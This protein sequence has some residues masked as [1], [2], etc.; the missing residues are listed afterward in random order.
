[1]RDFAAASRLSLTK[2]EAGGERFL[3]S[4]G[5]SVWGQ[6]GWSTCRRYLLETLLTIGR[7][8]TVNAA[9]RVLDKSGQPRPE[10]PEGG[11]KLTGFDSQKS[12]DLL[13]LKYHTLEET[14]AFTL[15]D[16]KK[17]GWA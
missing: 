7:L 10:E 9:R 17:R 1:M 11:Q 12:V 8:L 14:T 2:P 15:E 13:G 6:W 16:F 4:A 3:I 5:S